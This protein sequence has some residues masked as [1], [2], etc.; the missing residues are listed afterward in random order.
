MRFRSSC[1]ACLVL[2][3]C[4]VLLAPPEAP[5]QEARG[6]IVGKIVDGTGAVVPGAVVTIT[7]TAMGT[8]VSP[9][10]NAEGGY[11]APYLIPGSYQIMVEVPGFKKY[12]RDGLEVRVNDRLEVNITLELGGTTETVTVTG[13]TPLLDTASASVGS[14]IDARRVA[15][16]P[17]AHGQP[18]ALIG[19]APGVSFNAGSATLNRPFE[20]THIA[21]YAMGGA[22]SNRSD[23]TI[24][25]VPATATANA[26]EIISSYVPPA[27]I[28]Q[29]FRVQTAT[30]DAAFGQTE[31]GVI[32]I[33]IKSGTNDL[34]GT[35]YYGKWHP[36]LLANYWLNNRNAQPEGDFTYNRWGG[37]ASGPVWLPKLYDG[38]NKT[39]FL[40]GY[41]AIHETRGRNNNG[42]P[43]V[44]T[45]AMK[46]GDF[47]QLLAV[48][49]T[50]QIYDP[51]TRRQLANGR[52]EADPFPGNIIPAARQS[53]IA[54]NLLKYWSDPILPGNAVGQNNML[55]PNLP[56]TITYYTH[57]IR[58]DHVISDKQR[59]FARYS[60]Y[61]RDSNYNNYLHSIATGEWFK[62]FSNNAT[63]DDVYTLS[64]TTVLNVRYGYNR[65]VRTSTANP[66]GFG[67][68]YTALGFPKEYSDAI[69][70]IR[71]FPGIDMNG[72]TNTNH[73]DFWRPNDTHAFVANVNKI[74]GA[75]SIK[76][77]V[78]FRAYRENSSFFGNDGSGR[79]VFDAKWTGGPLDNS[80]RPNPPLGLSVAAFLLGLPSSGS[81]TRLASYAEQSTNWGIYVHDDWKVTRK[82][83]LNLGLRWEYEGPLTE[84]YNRSVSGFD[85]TYVQ[86]FNAAAQA[87]YAAKTAAL[88][89]ELPASQFKAMGGLTFAGVGGNGRGLYDTGKKN[90]MPRIGIAYQLRPTTVLRGGYGIYYGFLGQRRG[91]VVQ[92]GFNGITE[93][94]PTNDNGLTFAAT[95]ANPFPN[96]IS[97][98]KGA[99]EGG[100]TFINQ[101]LTF[102]DPKPATPYMQRWEL[103]FQ[104]EFPG[105]FVFDG[106]YMGNRGTDIEIN[107]NINAVPNQYYS[108]S[109]FRDVPWYNNMTANVPNPFAGLLAGTTINGTTV[110]KNVLLK[111]YPQ[112]GTI[113]TTT[114]QGYSWYHAL[115]VGVQKRFSKGYTM[116]FNYTFSKFMQATEYL[117]P[118]DP[119]PI[120]TISDVD[121]PHRITVSSI[122]ELP[123]G[124]GRRFLANA[125]PVVKGI[126]GG[127]QVQGIYAFQSGRPVNFTN[128]TYTQN[129]PFYGDATKIVLPSDQ[130]SPDQWFNT[131]VFDR[132]SL[133][134]WGYNLRT[135]PFRFSTLRTDPLN[136][137]DLSLIK[138][139]RIAEGKNL[140]IR[141]E[142]LN[143]MNHPNFSA[144]NIVTT[145]S[146]FG[147]A[148]G[149]QNYPRNIQL[150]AKFLF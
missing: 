132:A 127:W 19:L 75:H 61:T 148:I 130:R 96:G 7:N 90:F 44:P 133:T 5:A 84:R 139:T 38:R 25:G 134:Q 31:G 12:V 71:R 43:T 101:N 120:E 24:D 32:N 27:D 123:F 94:V 146:L 112:F 28:V 135:F 99:S 50:Y 57:T 149:T 92:H 141:A 142:F 26:G 143:A 82:L 100:K 116:S 59:M 69:G 124:S 137:W 45:P 63:I 104:Q 55:E 36:A 105:G 49:P 39:F 4:A 66:G 48:N 54:K 22:K 102:F 65:F 30:F 80:A 118:A 40:W 91:D 109:P 87:A 64:P 77:G 110:Q 20:P 1:T 111:P 103:G 115:L 11:Q 68:D 72:Y 74:A 131:S 14:V 145:N 16:L 108:T 70:D 34:H 13:E 147:T 2:L 114:N 136:N 37:S 56:E 52:I 144:P 10:T 93:F 67:L 21:G 62:F 46:N 18:F 122:Y 107:R 33:A 81:V 51:A 73:S 53:Q 125:H 76:T 3:V 79:F 140:Q 126:L 95:L 129:F 15:E 83:T 86:D 58:G 41:E 47:S 117:N 128:T 60:F 17:M 89:P 138:N 121:T 85:P 42:N 113:T 8:K 29:E 6:T 106:G 88:V 119:M 97:P 9:A 35:A 23:V 98:A 150:T 78:E